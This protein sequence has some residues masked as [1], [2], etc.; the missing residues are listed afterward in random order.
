MLNAKK[1]ENAMILHK[2]SKKDLHENTGIA[3]TT[4]NAILEGGDT[5]ISTIEKIAKLLKVS[6]GYLF[7]EEEAA[8]V[9]IKT[10]GDYSPGLIDGNA[11][12]SYVNHDHIKWLETLLREKDERIKELKERIKELKQK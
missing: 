12:V 2:I 6:I 7:D 9:E 8:K 1:I 5:K 11:N 3:I 10:E 4:L